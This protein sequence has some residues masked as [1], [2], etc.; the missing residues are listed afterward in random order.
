MT[1]KRSKNLSL[2]IPTT[3]LA[4]AGLL[5]LSGCGAKQ[6]NVSYAPLTIKVVKRRPKPKKTVLKKIAITDRV[7]FKKNSARLLKRSHPVLD[8]VVAVMEKNT[9]I[10][11]VEIQGHTDARGNDRRNRQLS[12]RRADSVR[13]YLMDKGV[14]AE[15][16]TAKGYGEERPLVDNDSRD[17]RRQNRR[18]EFQIL[19]QEKTT[20][21]HGG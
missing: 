18:V 7:Q 11:L 14:D 17:N 12:Q 16:L 5:A 10:H 21:A 6:H 9:S 4:A 15:R 13:T 3:L 19:E 20:M 1:K 2:F 8:Q